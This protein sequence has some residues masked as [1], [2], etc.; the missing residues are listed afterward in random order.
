MFCTSCQKESESI[1][2]NEIERFLNVPVNAPSA[3]K[4]IAEDMRIKN[5]QKPFI[6]NY[7]K[8][9]GYP[10]WKNAIVKTNHST[11][12]RGEAVEDIIVFVPFVLVS[13]E[14]VNSLL[15][16]KLNGE[17]F[18]KLFEGGN[19]LSYGWNKETN[20]LEPNAEDVARMI[21]IMEKEIFG[22]NK[23]KVFDNLLFDNSAEHP[24][25]SRFVKLSERVAMR[26]RK[27]IQV[28]MNGGK[29]YRLMGD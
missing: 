13:Q 19:Y 22:G 4:R 5:D 21:M 16:C 2:I 12:R 1:S 9:Q 10:N 7:I 24:T 27:K 15:D 14:F 8:T 29:Q 23:F 26:V 28:V 17:I 25:S 20:R 6:E 11:L 18:Y 3:I